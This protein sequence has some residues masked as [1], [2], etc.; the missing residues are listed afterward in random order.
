[1]KFNE[2]SRVKIPSILH[3]TRLGYEYISLKNTSWD[4]NTN[5][6]KDLFVSSIKN[7]NKNKNLKDE[8]VLRVYDDI[9]LLLDN[10]DLGKAFYERLTEKSGIKLI[11]FDDF[12]NNKFN[13][14]TELTYK[15][16]EDE[17]RP[18][19]ILLINGMP[20]VFIE[21][22]KPNNSDGVR[23]ERKRIE[24]RFQ[25]KAF[26]KFVNLTQLMIFSNNMEYD[27]ESSEPI[28]G[29][30]YASSSYHKPIF[31]YFR[32]EESLNLELLLKPH[33]E[34]VENFILK[35][36]NLNVI[37]NS[38]EFLTNKNP[39]TP[40]NRLSASILS[41]ERLAFIVFLLKIY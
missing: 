17:F 18:D 5:I 28:Q 36:N 21:V 13:V 30:F 6:F 27:N 1:M 16:D 14:V 41:K 11:D 12:S 37:K 20:L 38:P 24:T 2:D 32:E 23:A 10:D 3:L 33:N 26:K 31:N 39:N 25:N 34:E 35:D 9:S 19:I 40:T 22:K 4:E 8:E 15:K 29:A 7:I